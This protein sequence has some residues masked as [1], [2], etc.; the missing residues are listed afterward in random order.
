MKTVTI[1][2]KLPKI[3]DYALALA[4]NSVPGIAETD[5]QTKA[6]YQSL[7]KQL[8]IDEFRSK[9][10]FAKEKFDQLSKRYP[11]LKHKAA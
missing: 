10:E 9:H 7:A 2:K 8:F 4:V 1:I 3:V 5:A 6:L 11:R